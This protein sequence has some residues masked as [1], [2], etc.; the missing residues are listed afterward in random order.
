M[1][2][3]M[4]KVDAGYYETKI[5]YE[6]VTV[7]V[8]ENTMTVRQ[9]RE[10]FEIQRVAKANHR[11]RRREDEDR[12]VEQFRK[13]LA[14]EYGLV[15]HPKEEKLYAKAWEFGHS[16]GLYDVAVY[17]DELSELVK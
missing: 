6:Y 7:P 17:Y 2:T 13:D 16:S 3:V 9:A 10:H 5:P 8:D 14:V 4:E 1:A 15:G 11:R 12:L